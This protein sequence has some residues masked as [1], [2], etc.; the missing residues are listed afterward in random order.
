L[1]WLWPTGYDS[2]ECLHSLVD[3]NGLPDFPMQLVFLDILQMGIA[4]LCT[5]FRQRFPRFI[6]CKAVLSLPCHCS[7]VGMVGIKLSLFNVLH[8]PFSFMYA[9]RYTYIYDCQRKGLVCVYIEGAG[10]LVPA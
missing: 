3:R 7:S 4:H 2:P 5:A 8:I 10:P 6:F 1:S 9:S